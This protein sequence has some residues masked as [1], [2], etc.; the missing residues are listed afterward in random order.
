MFVA[1]VWAVVPE[2]VK[3]SCKESMVKV[4]TDELDYASCQAGQ[5]I[6]YLLDYSGERYVL[7]RCQGSD[8]RIDTPE[9]PERPEDIEESP[10]DKSDD[11]PLTFKREPGVSL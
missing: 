4:T 6:G 10:D 11:P 1:S 7:C 2:P 5:K 9:R 3:H 8:Q